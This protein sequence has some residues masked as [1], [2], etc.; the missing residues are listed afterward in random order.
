MKKLFFSLLAVAAMA[1]C[2]KSELAERPNIDGGD[3]EILAKSTALSISTRAPFEGSTIDA[4]HNLVAKVWATKSKGDYTGS[5]TTGSHVP[6]YNASFKNTDKM[7][8][9]DANK[10]GFDATVSPMYFP[11]DADEVYLF[12]LYPYDLV[13][14]ASTTSQQTSAQTLID[15][16]SDIMVARQVMASKSKHQQATPEYP[17]LAF[18]HMLTKLIVK[19]KANDQAAIDA[20]GAITDITLTGAA[21]GLRNQMTVECVDGVASTPLTATYG[22]SGGSM[23]PFDFYQMDMTATPEYTDTAFNGLT[24]GVDLTTTATNVAYVL[25]APL[26]T[27]NTSKDDFTIEVKTKNHTTAYEVKINLLDATNADY[28][29]STKGKYFEITLTFKATEIQAQAT[30][31][32][33][34]NGGNGGADIQ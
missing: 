11:A 10:V 7:T 33:W 24:P 2:S 3:V 12:G 6:S 25:V 19:V 18:E 28:A 17:T 31:A 30:V 13:W 23:D 21:G 16:K 5:S 34:E 26:S 20:W 15:G 27:P 14:T 4:T 29:L 9:V 32:A 22:L 1:S 8:F